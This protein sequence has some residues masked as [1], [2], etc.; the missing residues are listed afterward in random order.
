MNELA[1]ILFGI[2]MYF[3]GRASE[4]RSNCAYPAK[5]PKEDKQI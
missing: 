1:T 2:A 5:L 3:L 4:M